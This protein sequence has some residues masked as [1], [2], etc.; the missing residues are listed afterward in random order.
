M[1]IIK[2]I[3]DSTN[4]TYIG[5]ITEYPDNNYIFQTIVYGHETNDFGEVVK[6]G[7]I[8]VIMRNGEQYRFDCMASTVYCGQFGITVSKDGKR[9]YIIS[10]EVG[11][12][13]YT[14]N[15]EIKWKTRYT[16]IGHV[17]ENDD[18][19]VTCVA[20]TRI[21][22]LDGNGK[23]IK[24]RK[25]IHYHAVKASKNVVYAAISE[26]TMALIH[27][28]SLEILWKTPI[29]KL[30]L[31]KSRYALIYNQYLIIKGEKENGRIVFVPVL[32]SQNVYGKSRYDATIASDHGFDSYFKGMEFKKLVLSE[33]K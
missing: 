22:L 19:T 28:Q 14:Y 26:N 31:S 7:N 1:K 5:F 15:G 3:S 32:L 10:D 13:C 6:Q 20:S 30:G 27:S 8:T 12:W 24:E 33:V 16:S 21:L 4:G 9:I 25:I 11:L 29:K 18:Q 23:K 2:K 17:I